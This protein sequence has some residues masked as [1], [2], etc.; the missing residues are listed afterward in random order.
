MK[1]T[2]LLSLMFLAVTV[3]APAWASELFGKISYKGVPL[4]DA[5]VTVG[6]KSGK[7]NALGFYSLTLDP[8]AYTLKVKLPDG[9]TREEKVDVFPQATEKNLKLE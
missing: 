3:A 2:F 9:A 1:R 5:E 7:T 6:D 8:G 4:K